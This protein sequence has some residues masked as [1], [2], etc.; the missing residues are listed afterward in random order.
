[1]LLT[2]D[3]TRA[4]ALSALG[5]VDGVTP[6]LDAL[7]ARS[8][9]FETA[10]S[11]SNMTNPSHLSIMTGLP[12]R[13]HGVS[14]NFVAMPDD[15]DTLA[16]ALGREGYRTA[17]FVS[18]RPLAAAFGWAG[19]DTLP[20]VVG[21]LDARV[22]TDRAV[23]WLAEPGSEPFFAWVHYW[24][25]HTMYEP[26]DE[27][28][29]RFY[30]GDPAAGPGPP[31]ASAPFFR[32]AQDFGI[33][34]RLA[35]W[36]GEVRDPAWARAKYTAEVHYTDREVGRLLAAL[37][38]AGQ[39]ANTL[40]VVVGDHGESLGEHGIY[41]A[42]VGVY[43]ET[44]RVPLILHVPGFAGQRATVPAWTLDIAPTLGELLGVSLRHEARGLSLASA[45]RGEPNA[46]LRDRRQ[47]VHHHGGD[48]AIAI[49]EGRW[50]LIWPVT[51]N[52][53]VLRAEPELFDLERDPQEQTDLAAQHPEV[54]ARLRAAISPWLAEAR[55]QGDPSRSV[56]PEI[57]Q[58][59]EAMGYVE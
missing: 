13:E 41:Y 16:T 36:L 8:A 40:I 48:R 5:G 57:R 51:S 35:R 7:A 12:T 38:Q 22:V 55:G 32:R 10:W 2:L 42:H 15:L 44:L 28:F 49:R 4:D 1:L 26:P 45:L 9:V 11:E 43:E 59:L 54:V 46:A 24:N 30:Q 34:P 19:F 37:E 3:T 50:K 14:S 56:S 29:E 27:L 23:A 25:P 21:E 39:A 47:F 31:L 58:Q 20:E 52:D 6:H 18:A 53:R 33:G 17:A